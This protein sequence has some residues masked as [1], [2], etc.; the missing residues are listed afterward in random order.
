MAYQRSIPWVWDNFATTDASSGYKIGMVLEQGYIWK[1]EQFGVQAKTT[2]AAQDTNYQTFYLK[3]A[4]GNTIA[5][6][7]N[8]PASSGLAIGPAVATGVDDS[9]DASYQYIDATDA[10]GVVYVTTEA[11][12]NGRAMLGVHGWVKATPMRKG[13]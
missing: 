9:M 7:A 12:G 11:T 2:Y 8:G 3:D 5:S 6:V 4:S 13:V 1:I 10:E